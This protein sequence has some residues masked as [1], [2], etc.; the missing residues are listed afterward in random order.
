MMTLGEFRKVTEH[1]PDDCK[2]MSVGSSSDPNYSY[3]VDTVYVKT[4]GISEES[5]KYETTVIVA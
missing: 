5:S 1:L 4:T 3:D 2:L